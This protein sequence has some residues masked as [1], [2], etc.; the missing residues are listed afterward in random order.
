MDWFSSC[1][2]LLL[3]LLISSWGMEG[4]DGLGRFEFDFNHRF[5]DRVVGIL[6]GDGLPSRDSPEYYRVMA[7]RDRLIRGRRLASGND[8]SLVTFADGNETVRVDTLGFLHY[9]NVTV[10]TP[11]EW[12]LVALDTGSDLFW[13]PCDC[14]NCVQD[15][16][17][18]GGATLNL[19]VYSPN[20]SSTSTNVLCNSTLCTRGDRCPSS[21]SSCPYQVRYLSN[22]TSSTGFLVEDVL[23]LVTNDNRSKAV[24]ARVTLGCGQVQT[25]VFHDGAAPNGLFGL[26]LEDV[27]VPSVLAKQG[28]SANSFSM[29]FGHDGTGRIGFGDKGSLDQRETPF[30]IRQSRPTYNVTVNQIIVG[31]NTADLEFSA[32]FDSGTSFTY[33]TDPAYTL[34]SES[35]NSLALD[36]RYQADS[37]LPFEYCYA[38]NQ[39]SFR[40]PAVNLTMKGGDTY[41]VYHPLVVIPM[42]D[43]DVYCLAVIKIEDISIIGQ[44]FMTG[45]RIV[46]DRE[47]MVLGWKES[48]CYSGEASSVPYNGTF[49]TARPPATSFNPEATNIP[50]QRRNSSS[51]SSA[52]FAL[53]L[54]ILLPVLVLLL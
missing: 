39:D 33:L 12:F 43:T 46:F 52:S 37:E 13:L 45:Y 35:F 21:L 30:N 25:G 27:A 17:S 51:A 8:Q 34:I 48:D 31:G 26:G 9:A 42:K 20:A 2:I 54:L 36:K 41:P 16:K 1:G 11:P 28:V 50:S 40:Y 4:C 10:G 22:G 6:P 3:G 49:S 38:P 24:D 19:N 32:V 15:L 29:C 47:K 44:N 7:H 23:H 53:L 14:T 18:P 5:S